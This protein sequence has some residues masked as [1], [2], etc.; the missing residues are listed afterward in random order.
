LKRAMPTAL[1]LGAALTARAGTGLPGPPGGASGALP[2]CPLDGDPRRGLLCLNDRLQLLPDWENRSS[3]Q[4][5][6]HLAAAEHAVQLAEQAWLRSASPRDVPY[7]AAMR[8]AIYR[9]HATTQGLP[10]RAQLCGHAKAALE[11]ACR[12]QVCGQ[13]S[14]RSRIEASITTYQDACGGSAPPA[15]SAPPSAE[16]ADA[17]E[18]L[19]EAT[20]S[21]ATRADAIV[22]VP[23]TMAAPGERALGA[24]GQALLDQRAY[25]DGALD[26]SELD[27]KAAQ[28]QFLA[29]VAS[30]EFKAVT[31]VDSA[32]VES[33]ASAVAAPAQRQKLLIYKQQLA[34][35]KA[36]TNPT[37]YDA[38]QKKSRG[39]ERMLGF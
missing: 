34:A 7:I 21:Y 6:W 35:G 16:C 2:A 13:V 28:E 19:A 17:Y 37:Q 23:K 20:R 27:P 1:L 32:V 33:S 9:V 39:G 10:Y 29:S 31:A 25:V 22:S 3:E 18:K 4:L 14:E 5:S 11:R 15:C 30:A 36:P 26:K 8:I 24:L 38:F 12:L